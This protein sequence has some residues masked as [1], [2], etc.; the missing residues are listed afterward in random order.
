M[1]SHLCIFCPNRVRNLKIEGV[2]ERTENVQSELVSIK[3][4]GVHTGDPMARSSCVR[5]RCDCVL[6]RI[7]L[8]YDVAFTILNRNSIRNLEIE[9]VR[10]RT[11]N[12]QS[13]LVS[14]KFLIQFGQKIHKCDV[15][16]QINTF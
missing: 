15:I 2:R 14:I 8:Y 3:F 4:L 11:E 13:E 16:I 10:E 5:R 9:G 6:G 7:S 12:V 1:T